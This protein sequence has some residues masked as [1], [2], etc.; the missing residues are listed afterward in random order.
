MTGIKF[1]YSITASGEV[2]DSDG[3]LKFV[4]EANATFVVTDVQLAEYLAEV[5]PD[6][7]DSVTQPEIEQAITR[8]P[9]YLQERTP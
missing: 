7:P 8:L 9:R 6:G 4:D 3:N 5:F 1:H 2:R